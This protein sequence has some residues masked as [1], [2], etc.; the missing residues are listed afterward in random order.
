[1]IGKTLAHFEITELVGKGGMGEV[2]RARDTKLGRDVAVKVL[3][4]EFAGDPDRLARF[5][6]EAKLLAQLNHPNIASIYGLEETPEAV[7]LVMELVEGDDLAVIM[8]RGA[9]PVDDAIDIAKQIADGLE[10]AHESGVV[11]RDLKPAN[12]KR[13]PDGKVK[14][15]DF[16][17]AMALAGQSTA[18]AGSLSDMAT[19]TA[20]TQ[21]GMILGTAAYM[22]PE[23]ARGLAVDRRT[24]IWA[25]G[26]ILFEML[27]GRRLF[28]GETVTDTL[29][30]ILRTDPDWD[31]L[32]D[33]LPH[34]VER[35]LRRCL[36]RDP[37]QRLRDI[38]EARVRLEQPDAESGVL[39]GPI[40]PL[41]PTRSARRRLL[42]WALAGLL[43][44]ATGYLGFLRP[45]TDDSDGP[46]QLAVP[47]PDGVQFQLDTSFPALPTIS[48]DG[49][50]VVFGGVDE[51]AKA[52]LFLRAFASRQAVALDGTENAQYPF[53]SPDSRFIAFFD[54]NE[55]L[56]KVP[57]DGG[58]VQTICPAANAK[59]GSWSKDGVII[60]S[61][62][63][64][65]PL[66]SV[67]AVGGEPVA[68][69]DLASDTGFDSHRHPW[70]LP[71][72]RRFLYVA[73]GISTTASEV[74]LAS[75]DADSTRV[76]MRNQ[77]QAVFVDGYL[78]YAR[79]DILVAHAFDPDAAAFTADPYPIGSDVV[80]I[81]GASRSIFSVSENGRLVLMR[82]KNLNEATSLTWVDRQGQDVAEISERDA[83]DG[84]VLS[85]DDRFIALLVQD[86]TITDHD[87]WI[88]EIERGFRERFTFQ[89]TD[90]G[91]PLWTPDGQFLY[92]VANPDGHDKVYRKDFGRTRKSELVLDFGVDVRIW[93][94]GPDGRFLL[95][96][97]PHEGTDLDLWVADLSGERE[98]RLLVQT[99]GTDAAA[100]FSPD[101]QWISYWS[102]ETGTGQIY[103]APW[104]EMAWTRR[105]S[106][107]TGTWQFWPDDGKSI[108]FQDGAG[109]VFSATID[110][111][112]DGVKI[113][114][115][116]PL[117]S[118]GAMQFDS[119]LIDMTGD[120]ERFVVVGNAETDPP[121]H[122]D[123]VFGWP[124]LLPR[125]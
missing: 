22:S 123:V 70:F 99:P 81:G 25:F 35:V 65:Q 74:R 62:S 55:G 102:T 26:V 67:P 109:N 37:R 54:R 19:L 29:A 121:T 66:M 50:H 24:D 112:A 11:H 107:T 46:I 28:A 108:V 57:V 116:E 42:P 125:R 69:T 51:D 36:T 91:D 64:D 9:L 79:N 122:F 43:A 49:R 124:R 100:R 41:A 86:Q 32:P 5:R 73:R 82:G 31:S 14:I 117:F 63:H 53:W 88:Y 8:S 12:L 103:L 18:E 75:L 27:T 34:Q 104:P 72:G 48:P 71:D 120:G 68:I 95:Y 23:Q 33:A 30:G 80:V 96:S 94:I 38:G 45:T 83:F 17:L 105:V 52:C 98:P 119:P 16:G 92:Y 2:W 106:T 101:G 93:D 1:M 21:A 58:P 84:V 87:I 118:H 89:D 44:L 56:K 115:P 10:E 77:T 47:A 39:P 113:G 40:P 20:M 15:L 76:V 97:I 114:A 4:P 110:G 111:D 3:P 60:F 90:E 59:G 13:T 85:P 61:P 7:F 6:R 78:L